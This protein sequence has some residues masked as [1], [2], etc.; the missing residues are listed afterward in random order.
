MDVL[1]R[2]VS[3]RLSCVREAGKEV[4]TIKKDQFSS[5]GHAQASCALIA[6]PRVTGARLRQTEVVTRWTGH[7]LVL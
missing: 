7:Q 2:A 5:Q 4:T 1:T 3:R 6:L